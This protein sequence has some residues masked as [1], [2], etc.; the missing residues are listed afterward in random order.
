MEAP[1]LTFDDGPSESTAEIVDLL[2]EY[3]VPAT[4]FVIGF[5]AQQRPDLV[6]LA[7]DGDHV[8]GNHTWDHVNLRGYSDD[9]VVH[10]LKQT[11]D[12]ITE[13][14]GAPPTLFRAPW[15]QCDSRVLRLAGSLGLEHVSA[16][17]DTWDYS[18]K[19]EHDAEYVADA[20]LSAKA[21]D[22]ILLHDGNGDERDAP[23]NPPRPKTVEA[24][25]RALPE[26]AERWREPDPASQRK[27]PEKPGRRV[28]DRE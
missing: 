12:V 23:M 2:C 26:F 7:A 13:I 27:C 18:P 20:M 1:R 8:V 10:K 16:N 4:F 9:D 14:L 21:G 11:N 6:K 17:V 5:R 19:P 25:R 22:I 24:L 28:D 3:G 15:L